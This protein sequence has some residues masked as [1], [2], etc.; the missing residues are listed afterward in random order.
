MK[1]GK[2]LEYWTDGGAKNK[3]QL[4]NLRGNLARVGTASHL[5]MSK[6]RYYHFELEHDPY[7]FGLLNMNVYPMSISSFF[8]A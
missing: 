1:A 8:W 5:M 2:E 7:M 6:A 3:L 4:A